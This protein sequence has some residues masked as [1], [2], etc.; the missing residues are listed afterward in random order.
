MPIRTQTNTTL[1][2]EEFR[3][4]IKNSLRG[5]ATIR[6]RTGLVMHEIALHVAKGRAWASPPLR[7]MIDR[8]GI[9]LR[10]PGGRV[11][12]QSLITFAD[13]A[14]RHSWSAQIVAAVRERHPEALHDTIS[15]PRP[16]NAITVTF[17]DDKFATS[18][19]EA[20]ITLQALAAR[21]ERTTKPEKTRLPWVKCARFGEQ[22]T[23]DGSLRHNANMLAITGIEADYDAEQIGYDEAK[24]ILTEAGFAAIL[25]TSPS[26]TEDAPRWRVLC[27]LS[28][29]YPP[30]QRDRF[31]ARV[32]G[33]FGG[34]FAPESWVLSQSYYFGSINGNS[35]HHAAVIEGVC[36][37]Q[38]DQ[39][40]AGAIGRP[41]KPKGNGDG[42]H[43]PTSRPED[44]S[45]ARIGGLVA[46]LLANVSNA[47]DG[48]KHD[49][50]FDNG[51]TLG[52]Y[53]HLIGWT[54]SE[55]VDRLAAALPASVEDWNS[56]RR[57]AADAI[58]IGIKGPLDLEDRPNPHPKKSPPPGSE[59]DGT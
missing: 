42:R 14:V 28:C 18:K 55:A 33:V 44:I 48:S 11:R 32:N 8:E 43:H 23:K 19:R 53:L 1:I 47:P 35:S 16:V 7:P 56:A 51:R 9:A 31:M 41:Q 59:Q 2:V 4:L 40:D 30:D 25:Y 15:E 54:E 21:I 20:Q 26:H 13:N 17:F 3:P 52:G 36:I 10:D 57:T 58:A 6:F 49:I 24:R 12:W 46:K 5:F 50:L 27:P 34:I 37:D 29:E 22:K 38:A 45:D 39:L